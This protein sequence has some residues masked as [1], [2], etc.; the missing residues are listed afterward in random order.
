MATPVLPHQVLQASLVGTAGPTPHGLP[1][2]EPEGP[3][4]AGPG[5]GSGHSTN[6]QTQPVPGSAASLLSGSCR[7]ACKKRAVSAVLMVFCGIST[8]PL[9]ALF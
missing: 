1:D 4:L 7:Q 5:D 6:H 8:R 3:M 9:S 2:P